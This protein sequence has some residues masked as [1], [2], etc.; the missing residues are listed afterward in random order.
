MKSLTATYLSRLMT[1]CAMLCMA[2][3]L[4]AGFAAVQSNVLNIQHMVSGDM[5]LADGGWAKACDGQVDDCDGHLVPESHDGG[6][7]HHHHAGGETQFGTPAGG[8]PIE[9]I[10]Y[11]VALDLRPGNNARLAG[12]Y[13]GIPDQP[14]RA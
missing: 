11:A 5:Q 4:H 9:A 10:A 8:F 6:P 2:A 14:P 7:V 12:R 1:V 3:M 13:V